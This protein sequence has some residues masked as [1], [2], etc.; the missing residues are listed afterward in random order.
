MIKNELYSDYED[1]F[2]YHGNT[3][4]EWKQKKYGKTIKRDWILFN[5]VEEAQEFFNDNCCEFRTHYF[6]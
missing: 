2:E 3:E 1:C 5:S 4:I 6:Q